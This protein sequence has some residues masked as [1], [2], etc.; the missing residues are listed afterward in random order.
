MEGFA[1]PLKGE[2]DGKCTLESSRHGAP[3]AFDSKARMEHLYYANNSLTS[4]LGLEPGALR[5]LGNVLYC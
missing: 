1:V 3:S 5:M 4:K 2:F